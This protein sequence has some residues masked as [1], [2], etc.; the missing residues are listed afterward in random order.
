MEPLLALILLEPHRT[1]CLDLKQMS[2]TGST[3]PA[4]VL[5][6][7]R[8]FDGKKTLDEVVRQSGYQPRIT[9]EVTLKALSLGLLAE[10]VSAPDLDIP[11]PALDTEEV[12]ED[13]EANALSFYEKLADSQPMPPDDESGLS[14][15]FSDTLIMDRAA[16]TGPVAF[17]QATSA[18][19]PRPSSV[20][21]PIQLPIKASEE[22]YQPVSRSMDDDGFE[23]SDEAF[24][25]S[26]APEEPLTR[27]DLIAMGTYV[28]RRRPSHQTAMKSSG[29]SGGWMTRMTGWISGFF[30]V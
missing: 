25:E 12:Y 18:A 9:L 7:L 26:Y 24:F 29:G 17:I 27:A 15:A 1:L 21:G 10:S 28:P 6:V 2:A 16:L 8:L 11:L 30:S 3:I 22:A 19:H 14:E 5:R 13:F 23:D 20:T 4:S